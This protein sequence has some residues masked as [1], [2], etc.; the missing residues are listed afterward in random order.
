MPFGLCNTPA[1]FERLMEKV[2][3]RLTYDSCLVWLRDVIVIGHTFEEHLLNLGKVFQRFRQCC[4]KL[5]PEKCQLLQKAI[6]YLGHM[7][8]PK[9]YPPT[10]RNWKP[11]KNGQHRRISMKLEAFWAYAHIADGLFPGSPILKNHWP[12][13]LSRI[14]P[15]SGLQGW[16][17]LPKRSRDPCVLPLFLLTP[18]QERGSSWTQTP[19]TSGLEECS[20]KYRTDR[21]ES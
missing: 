10:P 17:P 3:R 21:T 20:P 1:T 13:S 5:N 11:R 14:N 16:K 2:P 8:H 4:V 12:N 7:Y 6:R 15:S 18:S 19:V 9:G